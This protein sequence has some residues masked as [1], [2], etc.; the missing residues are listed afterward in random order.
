MAGF[1]QL[2]HRTYGE[3]LVARSPEPVGGAGILGHQFV[4]GGTWH[5]G[6]W[7]QKT[8]VLRC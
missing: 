7:L 6:E 3:L 5:P 1:S 4:N 8:L 2:V